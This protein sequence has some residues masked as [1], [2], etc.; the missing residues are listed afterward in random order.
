MR[1]K[2]ILVVD[3]QESL[4]AAIR[5]F[6]ELQGYRV[7]DV[8]GSKAAARVYTE[9]PPDAAIL[10]YSLPDGNG[11]QILEALRAADPTIP[12]IVLTGHGTIDLAVQAMKAG[13]EQ[14]ITKP[15]ELSALAILLRWKHEGLA[16]TRSSEPAP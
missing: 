1:S 12:V 8:P 2:H 13:A 10:D 5:E 11:I 6:L 15:V 4:R 14:F 16:S 9:D 7:S 3:D